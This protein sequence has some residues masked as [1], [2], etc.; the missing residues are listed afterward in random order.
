MNKVNIRKFS[1]I[2]KDIRLT[3]RQ[4]NL[5]ASLISEIGKLGNELI[6]E[7]FDKNIFLRQI[8]NRE[9]AS[10]QNLENTSTNIEGI[11]VDNAYDIN[12]RYSWENRNLIKLYEKYI[13]GKT[14][15]YNSRGRISISLIEEFHKSLYDP[16][17]GNRFKV[18][19]DVSKIIEK[20]KPGD[21]VKDANFISVASQGIENASLVMIEPELKEEYLEDLTTTL[22]KKM[23]DG[24]LTTRHIMIS[25]VVY[26]AI[27]PFA[28]GNGR[29]GR[30][31]ISYL[32]NR[33]SNTFKLPILLSEAFYE[34]EDGTTYKQL[35]KNVQLNDD[36]DSWN[37]WISFFIE[38]MIITKRNIE[39]RVRKLNDLYSLLSQTGITSSRPK[40]YVTN[41]F[42][43]HLAVRRDI[44]IKEIQK[45]FKVSQQAANKA[46]LNVVSII[47]PIEKES[48]L[49]VFQQLIDIMNDK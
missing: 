8:T 48:G 23:K 15:S 10:T 21:I 25:H 45:R 36:Y 47:Q 32:F 2:I 17:N 30:F 18:N 28:D 34:I 6:F 22:N 31:F 37:A 16:S 19:F 40:E 43:K 1:E 9:T 24:S 5:L 42:F 26:E 20:F 33:L 29:T 11:V 27:H 39:R 3:D 49:F 41:V 4:E 7:D 35:L 46:W 44:T 13:T 12:D 14:S 38:S